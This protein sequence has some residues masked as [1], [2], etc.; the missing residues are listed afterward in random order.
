MYKNCFLYAHDE[1]LKIKKQH[2]LVFG[3]LIM[4][5][6]MWMCILCIYYLLFIFMLFAWSFLFRGMSFLS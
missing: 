1:Q 5:P 2:D 6:N 4:C 3:H